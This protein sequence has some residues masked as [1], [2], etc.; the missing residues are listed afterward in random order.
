MT[1]G[2]PVLWPEYWTLSH[3]YLYGPVVWAVCNLD[4]LRPF[5]FGN[6]QDQFEE[7]S[8]TVLLHLGKFKFR[9]VYK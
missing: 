6:S 5:P 4:S 2:V 8:Y 9:S 3:E 1:R 7:L